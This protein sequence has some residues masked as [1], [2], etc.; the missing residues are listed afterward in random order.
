MVSTEEHK[1]RLISM[2][3]QEKRIFV[4]GSIAL[5]KFRDH[6]M[7]RNINWK[8]SLGIKQG[9]SSFALVIFHSMVGEE[10]QAPKYFQNILTVLKAKNIKAFVSYPNTDPGN[11]K[12]IAIIEKHKNNKHFFFY[13][14]LSR[15]VFLNI[16]K[17][18]LFIIGNSS[19]GILEAA[20]IPI[21]A[22]NVGLRQISRK[23][24]RN[25][26]FCSGN[27]TQINKAITKVM[28][29]AFRRRVKR[30]RNFYGDGKSS[31]RAYA[32]IKKYDFKKFVLKTEDPLRKVKK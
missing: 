6:H 7:D 25:V 22:V 3:E 21:P 5:D 16:Y 20:S 10:R 27:S 14:N 18:S 31:G 30:I 8:A 17:Q 2:G 32:I 19:S 12:L 13:K 24:G 15:Q 28:Q 1:R 26:L 9:F 23:S 4:I 29:P 11:K